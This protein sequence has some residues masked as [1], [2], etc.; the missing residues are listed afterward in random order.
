MY[1]E[2]RAWNASLDSTALNDAVDAWPIRHQASIFNGAGRVFAPRYR[3]AHIR[4]FTLADSLSE[5]ALRLAYTDVRAAFL[6]YLNHWDEGRPLVIAAHSQGSWHAR[7]LLQE[8]FDGKPLA[9][10]LVA[11]YI[12]GM[13]VYASDFQQL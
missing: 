10:R 4:V 5:A 12:P 1:E 8:F 3:Q 7:W 9:D 2:G 13:D 6:H 11:A